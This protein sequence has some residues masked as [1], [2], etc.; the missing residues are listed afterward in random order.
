MPH[1]RRRAPTTAKRAFG[2][3]RARSPQG[4]DAG[5][6]WLSFHGGS[7]PE[8]LS[9]TFEREFVANAPEAERRVRHEENALA[10]GHLVHPV[11]QARGIVA[12]QGGVELRVFVP[13]VTNRR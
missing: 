6:S 13:R 9:N 8:G 7:S 11:D 3:A 12:A 1:L 4:E 5:R 2:G 10:V